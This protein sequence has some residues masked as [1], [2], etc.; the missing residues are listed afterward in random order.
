MNCI[1]FMVRQMLQLA[2]CRPIILNHSKNDG[3]ISWKKKV[4]FKTVE[5]TD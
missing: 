1:Q 5:N 3:G 2:V 4:Y